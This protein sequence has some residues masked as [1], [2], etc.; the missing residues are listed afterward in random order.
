MKKLPYI[1]IILFCVAC[2][3]DGKEGKPLVDDKEEAVDKEVLF[4]DFQNNIKVFEKISPSQ[5]KLYFSNDITENTATKENLFDYDYFYN[6]SGVGIEDIN[7]DG[8]KDIFFC[9]NQV[10]NKLFLNKGGLVFEDISDTANINVNKGWSSGVTFADVNNDG[11]M[12]IYVSQGGPNKDKRRKNLLYINQKNLTFK[13]SAAI[14]GLNDK[15]IS[16]QSAFFDFDNDGDLDCVVS[17]EN[18]LYGVDPLTFY[19]V[20]ENNE[21]LLTRSSVH[22]Y[23]NDKGVFKNITKAAGLLK[24]AFGLGVCVGDINA[25]GWLDIYI[26]NDYYVPDAMY[27]NNHD[28]TFRD[29]IKDD[30]N[31]VS[32]YGMGVDIADMNND[33]HQDIFVLDMASSDHYRAKTLMASMNEQKFSLLVDSLD[34]QYQYM[35]NSLQLN[36]G[37]N[38]F[39]NISQLSGLSKTDWSWA[40]LMMDLDFDGHTDI[41]VTNGY[42]RYALDNDLR[43]KIVKAKAQYGNN[44]PLSVKWQLYYEMP[45]EKLANIMY[46]GQDDLQFK[47]VNRSWGMG[48]LS[49]SNGAAYADLDNDGDLEMVVNNIDDNAFLYKNTTIEKK[50]GNYLKVVANGLSSEPFAKVVIKYNGKVQMAE[51]KRVRGYLSSTEDAAYFGLADAQTVDTL[52]ITWL[53]GKY[54]ERYNLPVN[55]LQVLNEKDAD[56]PVRNVGAGDL[57]FK[58]VEPATIGL[59]FAHSENRYNDFEK[60]V[61]LP[62]KQSTLGPFVSKADINGDGRE[63]LFVGGASGQPGQL[64]VQG[65]TGFARLKCEALEKDAVF[66]D[67]EA[68][69]FD[70]DGDGDNDLYVVSGGNEFDFNSRNYIDRLYIN[71]GKGGFKRKTQTVIDLQ[72][73]S[74]RSVC[75][76][77]YDND[78]DM[79]IVVGN[80]I[81][82]H[83]YPKPATANVYRNDGGIFTEVVDKVAPELAAQ[84]IINKVIA[85]DFNNDGWKDL[86][87]VGEWASPKIYLNENGVFRDISANSNLDMD[88]GW[89]F[90]VAETDVN[91]DGFKDYILGNVGANIKFKASV[92]KPFKVY[93]SDFDNNGTFDVVLS[94]EYKGTYVPS[95]GKECST[96]QMP[97]ISE[98]FETYSDFANASLEDIYGDALKDAYQGEVTNFSS[99]LLM[100]NGDGT[101][102]RSV[103]PIMAQTFP[104]LASE[105]FDVNKDGF[106][107]AILVGNI[108]NT[109]AETPRLD[110]GYGLVL[111]SN[112]RDGYLPLS[113]NESGFYYKGNTKSVVLIEQAAPGKVFLIEGI[114]NESI[115]VFEIN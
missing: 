60:E 27:I 68:V 17:N 42:R 5:S 21:K 38:K 83:Q 85:T 109:E 6:G 92:E 11:W 81:I 84:G 33:G 14:Y 99:V 7:N 22:L 20:L 44:I 32:F 10:P 9:G 78:G 104:I 28:G 93:G 113:A 29:Q 102:K 95:R 87:A 62:Y 43:Q 26:A 61:L 94:N 72:H 46:R 50:L 80:R 56:K 45:S 98:K 107:D 37:N 52:R 25:D 89:W 69:F 2:G 66:E 57:R 86:I 110:N 49:F 34:L 15:G 31:Q 112:G 106:E 108:Y 111:L 1:F 24:P 97:F 91:N 54:E 82:P 115:A 19:K 36:L 103:L 75:A 18:E 63:D 47:N 53:S 76:V 4:A 105:F 114:N 70:V 79:D 23:R 88:K 59:D 73:Q 30:A 65:N 3:G 35:Y 12:D 55:T 40:G 71:D 13:E 51:T 96:Q 8:L 41:Y 16:T 90:N 64:F 48:D 100:N 101:F 74:G 77:D 39:Q 58:Q 67:M